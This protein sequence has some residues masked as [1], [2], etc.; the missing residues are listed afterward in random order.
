MLGNYEDFMDW[1][2][3][4]TTYL[5]ECNYFKA[6]IQDKELGFLEK[7]LNS[8]QNKSQNSICAFFNNEWQM[9]YQ[10]TKEVISNK[11]R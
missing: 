9:R 5:D 8:L 11:K 7:Y 2:R 10:I 6:R 4:Q 1:K 3:E